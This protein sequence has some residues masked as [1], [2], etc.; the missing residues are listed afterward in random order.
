M[1]MNKQ[2]WKNLVFLVGAIGISI[3]M[4]MFVISCTLIGYSVK[5]HC[6]NAQAE[7]GGECVPALITML[8]DEKK[9]YST[10][11]S[12]IWALGQLGDAR[13]LPVLEKYYT[14]EI[15]E[16]SS[17]EKELSQLLLSRAIKLIRSGFNMTAWAWR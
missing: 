11:N 15:P 16:R 12:A 2:K 6:K 7:Y 14:G 4:L 9:P 13:A 3:A 5:D 10:R 17:L 1:K 8:E